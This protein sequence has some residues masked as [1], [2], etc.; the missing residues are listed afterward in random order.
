M[1]GLFTWP[2]HSR[3]EPFV[4]KNQQSLIRLL[5]R[6]LNSC[7][8]IYELSVWLLLFLRYSTL[9]ITTF[10]VA[11]S[12]EKD[13]SQ[14]AFFS[15]RRIVVR[16]NS[17]N[18]FSLLLAFEK[19]KR[20]WDLSVGDRLCRIFAEKHVILGLLRDKWT[21][22]LLRV[23]RRILA[24]FFTPRFRTRAFHLSTESV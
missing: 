15:V 4:E 16:K 8:V 3:G 20:G 21:R 14:V 19:L 22:R 7:P 23:C 9:G 13:K 24:N 17:V 12:G 2:I 6:L 10:N 1:G 18:S 5:W 11:S